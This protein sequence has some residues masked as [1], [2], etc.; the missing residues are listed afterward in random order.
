MMLLTFGARADDA[1][2]SPPVARKVM[3][4]VSVGSNLGGILCEDVEGASDRRL[5]P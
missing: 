4:L 3:T 5:S 2:T 1:P